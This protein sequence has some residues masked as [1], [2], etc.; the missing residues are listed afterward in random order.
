[1]GSNTNAKEKFI[2]TAYKLFEAIEN[3]YFEKLINYGVDEA[4]AKDIAATI[5]AMTE[6]AIVM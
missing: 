4:N 1:M 6:G 2:E 3:L 5:S